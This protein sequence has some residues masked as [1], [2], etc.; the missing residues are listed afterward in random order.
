MAFCTKCGYNIPEGEKFCPNCG[1]PTYPANGNVNAAQSVYVDPK[2]HTA[3]FAAE[4]INHGKFLAA[5]CY[6]NVFF[7]VIGLL[8]E[9]NSKFIRFHLNQA[10]LTTILTLA[11]SIVCIIPIIGWI[12]GVVGGI[13][14]FV[15]I[16]MGI[17]NSIK[18]KAKELPV[19][20][21]Y[22][23]VYWE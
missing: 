20:G 6:L 8:A 14:S 3:Q 17:V 2:D 11:S 10:I 16:I 5:L 12:A 13:A 15:F 4:D 19:I 18:G 22:T 9:P 23:L 7:A 1:N 21:K